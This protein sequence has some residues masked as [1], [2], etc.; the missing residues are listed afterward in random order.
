MLQSTMLNDSLSQCEPSPF[1]NIWHNVRLTP[2]HSCNHG[3]GQC[4]RVLYQITEWLH[5]QLS[6]EQ[7]QLTCSVNIATH[8]AR[9]T[10]Q[11]C[12][13]S[14]LCVVPKRFIVRVQDWGLAGKQM[15]LLTNQTA[16]P[17]TALLCNL[18]VPPPF[19]DV[20]C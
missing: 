19:F 14:I 8:I 3:K 6:I 17:V 11:C 20:R 5:N 13:M 12:F 2:C 7:T 1:S 10:S 4:A 16:A 18:S 15:R 9:H